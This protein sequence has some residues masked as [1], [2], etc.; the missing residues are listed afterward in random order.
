MLKRRIAGL[1]AAPVLIGGAAVSQQQPAPQTQNMTPAQEAEVRA[2]LAAAYLPRGGAPDSLAIL[3]APPAPG[4]AAQAR[5]DEAAR[6]AQTLNGSPRWALAATDADL[7]LPNAARAFACA[8]GVEITEAGTPHT[9]TLLRRSMADVGLST[10]PTKTKYQR[11]RPFVVTSTPTCTPDSEEF[12][13]HDGSYPSGHSA[14]GWGWALVLAE[15]APDRQNQI[16]ARGRAFGQ[17]RV[18]C[19]VHWLSDT[20]EG[21]VMASATVARLHDSAEFRADMESARA[22]IAAV[23]AAGTAP[24][25]SC[26]VEAARLA[27]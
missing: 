24:A 2:I 16:L 1:I 8:L 5:D 6:A 26:A 11:T 19:N 9:Y 25:A 15:A 22:E 27:D 3:P 13:R 20:E 18:V 21:R 12:L 23:R 4:S 17:S 14:V 7:S 10:Y